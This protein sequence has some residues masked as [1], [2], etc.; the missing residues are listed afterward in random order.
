MLEKTL[1]TT[2]LLACLLAVGAS[3][4]ERSTPTDVKYEKVGLSELRELAKGR[5]RTNIQM[6]ITWCGEQT[7]PILTRILGTVGFRLGMEKYEPLRRP[8]WHYGND[9]RHGGRFFQIT[10]GEWRTLIDALRGSPHAASIN[11]EKPPAKQRF[12]V[13]LCWTSWNERDVRWCELFTGPD[14]P[15]LRKLVASSIATT[16]PAHEEFRKSILRGF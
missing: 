11:P 10:A 4:S 7:K 3:G 2:C 16:H 5:P 9:D 6:K 8:R 15:Q 13:I 12:H 1:T 14:D